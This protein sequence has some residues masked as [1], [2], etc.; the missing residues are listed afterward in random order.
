MIFLIACASII[1]NLF[2]N[3]VMGTEGLNW[4]SYAKDF[5]YDASTFTFFDIFNLTFGFHFSVNIAQIVL[6]VAAIII[7]TKTA[8]KIFTK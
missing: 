5:G 1:G 8:P 6:I 4:L 2:G 7:Y 3:M